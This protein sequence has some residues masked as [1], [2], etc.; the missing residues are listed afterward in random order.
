MTTEAGY[1][2]EGVTAASTSEDGQ[3][4]LIETTGVA[5]STWLSLPAEDIP[6]AVV[7]LLQAAGRATEQRGGKITHRATNLLGLKLQDV[8]GSPSETMLLLSIQTD[9]PPIPYKISKTALAQVA[10]GI[11]QTMGLLPT[12]QPPGPTQ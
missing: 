4:V 7:I 3:H 11:L 9:A 2:F 10:Q 5:G 8:P 1:H 6:R 12:G